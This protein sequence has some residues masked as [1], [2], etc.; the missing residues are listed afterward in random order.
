MTGGV[1]TLLYGYTSG[2]AVFA[3][4]QVKILFIIII[5]SY[6]NKI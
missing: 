1:A 5:I 4:F 3:G 2:A 6:Y